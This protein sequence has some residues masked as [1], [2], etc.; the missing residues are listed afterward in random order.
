MEAKTRLEI[1]PA[2]PS[3]PGQTRVRP[4][5]LTIVRERR[6]EMALMDKIKDSGRSERSVTEAIVTL[7]R[8][9][10]PTQIENCNQ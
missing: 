1:G 5:Q 9:R 6:G 2:K 10:I 3:P 4:G 8:S 7:R